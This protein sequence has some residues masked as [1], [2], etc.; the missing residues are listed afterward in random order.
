MKKLMS[1]VVAGALAF[2]VLA[3]GCS[4]DEGGT[5]APE[6]VYTSNEQFG[7]GMW[8][9]VSD[10]IVEYDE[11][12][13]K[14]GKETPLTDE[15][16]L[17]KYELIAECGINIAYPGY[18]YML[19]ATQEYNMKCLWAAH[20][21]GIKQLIRIPAL[22]EYF[23]NLNTLLS[24]G[25][26]TE[27]EAVEKVQGFLKPYLESEYADAFYGC[28][29][30]DE[31]G[32]NEYDM[33]G[34]AQR[35]FQTA[36]PDLCFY[37]NLFP[38]I[39]GGAQLSGSDVSITYDDY[40]SQYLEKIKTPYISYDHYPLFKNGKNYALESSFLQNMEIMR[41][42]ID[43]EG[44]DRALWTFLQSIQYGT[45]NRAL[46]SQG[47]ATFQV[48]SFMAYGGDGVQWFCFAPPPPNDGATVFRDNS[49]LDR[50]FNKTA[51]YDYVKA[52]NEYAQAMMPYYKNFTWKGMM[53]SSE[54]GG[55]GNF[56]RITRTEKTNVVQ[57]FEASD[58]AIAGV[59]EDKDGREG[60]MVVNFT[61]PGRKT[62]IDVTMTVKGVHNAIVVLNGE[63]QI[64]PVKNGKL[65]L[66]LKS[67]EG[68]FVI[69]Y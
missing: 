27:Q 38:V 25:V 52:A 34:T 22:S 51:T 69:P 33:L 47:D 29:I 24:S 63:K 67:G 42:A 26:V 45:R 14:T 60:F 55:E 7:V 13:K 4:K 41:K 28:M 21:V 6:P 59:F 68:A 15:E 46:E 43:D 66:A 10:K 36:A 16:F 40:I 37:V 64:V 65:S 3:G 5:P 53:T 57:K 2:S 56:K 39:A 19:W 48:Y 50:N 32:A 35:I 18:E 61:D 20:E 62:D 23:V 17:E 58:D 8:V 49:P 1:M 54:D 11:W 12:G 30:T 9:G 31:P 44:E